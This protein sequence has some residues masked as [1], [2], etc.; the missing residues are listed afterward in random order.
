MRYQFIYNLQETK[1]SYNGTECY[2]VYDMVQH[3]YVYDLAG[4]RTTVFINRNTKTICFYGMEVQE[5]WILKKNFYDIIKEFL[6]TAEM[7][8]VQDYVIEKY[9]SGGEIYYEYKER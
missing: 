4:K 6:D 9:S 1:G 5:H 3:D 7:L 2:Y 8:N